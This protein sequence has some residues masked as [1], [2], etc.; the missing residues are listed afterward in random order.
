MYHRSVPDSLVQLIGK[1]VLLRT[2]SPLH[3]YVDFV[4][5]GSLAAFL[6]ARALFIDK[7]AKG[8]FPMNSRIVHIRSRAVAI[9]SALKT[10]FGLFSVLEPDEDAK[11]DSLI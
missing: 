4:V 3:G 7:L 6:P 2:A 8:Y 5:V 9:I 10:C 11:K 1:V